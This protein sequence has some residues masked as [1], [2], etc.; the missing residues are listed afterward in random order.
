MVDGFRKSAASWLMDAMCSGEHSLVGYFVLIKKKKKDLTF[1]SL[2]EL[3]K[4]SCS[5]QLLTHP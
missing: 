3:N 4:L 5:E 2:S 1:L